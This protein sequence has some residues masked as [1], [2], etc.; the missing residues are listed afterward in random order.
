M[1]LF[2]GIS[3]G[4]TA[5]IHPGDAPAQRDITTALDPIRGIGADLFVALGPTLRAFTAGGELPPPSA[6]VRLAAAHLHE[7]APS[8]HRWEFEVAG[9]DVRVILESGEFIINH[10]HWSLDGGPSAAAAGS[11]AVISFVGLPEPR[12]AL[13]IHLGG[14]TTAV[15]ALTSSAELGDVDLTAAPKAEPAAD[16][17]AALTILGERSVDLTDPAGTVVGTQKIGAVQVRGF[18]LLNGEIFSADALAIAAAAAAH[19]WGGREAAT[20]WVVVFGGGNTRVTL[21]EQ[22]IAAAEAEL[23]AEVDFRP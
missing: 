12:P 10:G 2:K 13:R 17:I 8:S 20:E 7:T 14:S 3:A 11:D 16:H 9:R 6:A 5:L 15:S 21:G 19:T 23:F 22:A 18:D 4:T 1:K